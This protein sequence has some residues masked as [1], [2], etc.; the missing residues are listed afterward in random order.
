MSIT[1][2]TVHQPRGGNTG[3]SNALT[4]L[5]S[6]NESFQAEGLSILNEG[7]GEIASNAHYFEDYVTKLSEGLDAKTAQ[8][9]SDLA[10]NTRISILQ[11]SS[12][13][14]I[15]PVTALSLPMMRVAYP[16]TAIREGYPT[17]PV[18]QPKFK[19]TW[20]KPYMIDS[21][22]QKAYLPSAI[23]SNASLFKLKSL[24]AT[25]INVG[26]NGLAQYDMFT[27]V[28]ASVAAQ[29]EIDA[30]FTLTNVNIQALSLGGSAGSEAVDVPVEF[31]LDTNTNICEGTA[32]AAHTDGTLTTAKVFAK[33]NRSTG[34]LDVVALG[35]VVNSV[36]VV[37]Y[38]SSE[39]NNSA[40]QVGF[41][42]T[43]EDV[44]IGTGQPIESP[45]NIQ[46]MTDLMAMYNI[47][48]TVRHLE[49]MSTALA[50]SVDLQGIQHLQSCYDKQAANQKTS[51]SFDLTPPAN[52]QLGPQAWR[53]QIKMYIDNLVTRLMDKTKITAGKVVL[54][55]NPLDTQVISNVR[56]MYAGDAEQVNG[57]NQEFK[58]GSYTS[59][60]TSYVVLS[61]FNFPQ[62]TMWA[63]FLPSNPDQATLKYYPYSFNVVRGTTSPNAPNIPAIQMIKR[64]IFKEYT[65]MIGKITI[66]GNVA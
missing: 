18:S 52:F 63:A 46:H 23:G 57:V 26:A 45:I 2:E 19:V 44:V 56:W 61:S 30:N 13:S 38:L 15:S 47:D 35:G 20:L 55:G 24:Q 50:Q 66:V 14:G 27:P 53:E 65:Q 40:T 25:A 37:G 3:I 4:N 39:K 33:V 12:L 10:Q 11:E 8:E 21:S 5:K 9:F 54:F 58:V 34:R 22:G 7:F 6:L 51:M 32:V 49:I 29:D 64:H 48:A 60:I 16:K 1:Y 59:G 17:E 41:D 62:G 43:S 42:I 28:G 31:R 36:K